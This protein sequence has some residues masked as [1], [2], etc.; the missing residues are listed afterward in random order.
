MNSHEQLS[1][2]QQLM[3]GTDNIALRTL[4]GELALRIKL[5]MKQILDR[6]PGDTLKAKADRIGVSRTTM[7]VWLSER[8]R[9]RGEL[10]DKLARLTG[11]P[12]LGIMAMEQTS[13][14]GRKTVAEVAKLA[15][16][17]KAA[18]KL[19]GRTRRGSGQKRVAASQNRSGGIRAVRKRTRGRSV[20]D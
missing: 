19:H 4:M 9:P 14:V 12:I 15:S 17:G 1:A 6:V 11:F 10:A 18:S 16:G 8:H 3:R 7:Y 2:L 13:D 5:P 20:S